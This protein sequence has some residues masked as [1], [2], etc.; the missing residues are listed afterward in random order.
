M[1][2]PETRALIVQEMPIFT[3]TTPGR[4]GASLPALDVPAVDPAQVWPAALLRREPP[5][6][7]EVSEPE[8]VRHYVRASSWNF[9]VDRGMYPLGSCTMKYN[10]KTPTSPR[11]CRRSSSSTP[12]SPS[13][14]SRAR[15]A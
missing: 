15:C 13:T 10:P 8:V 2:T 14:R 12:T 6:L 4:S 1:S 5:A 11:R 9:H 7:P 3:Q